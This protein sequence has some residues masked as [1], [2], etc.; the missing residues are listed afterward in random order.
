MFLE[1]VL[2][3]FCPTPQMEF[4]DETVE[5]LR[6]IYNETVVDSSDDE[7]DE[8]TDDEDSD[9]VPTEDRGDIDVDSSCEEEEITIRKNSD[10]TYYIY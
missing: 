6:A 10:G 7:T 9:Y 3:W 4:D 2:E 8:E 5:V 1:Y